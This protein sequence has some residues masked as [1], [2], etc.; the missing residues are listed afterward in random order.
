MFF[1]TGLLSPNVFY[2][3]CEVNGVIIKPIFFSH[4]CLCA[5]PLTIPLFTCPKKGKLGRSCIRPCWNTCSWPGWRGFFPPKFKVCSGV[6]SPG[7]TPGPWYGGW[8]EGFERTSFTQGGLIGRSHFMGNDNTAC[9]CVCVCI[10]FPLE[11]ATQRG[12]NSSSLSSTVACFSY[13][14]CFLPFFLASPSVLGASQICE[15]EPE[16]SVFLWCL[17]P[18]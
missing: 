3:A 18:A 16:H 17:F 6:R 1:L 2:L 14:V 5:C 7:L 12:P 9:V 4:S 10:Q 13:W 8:L 15:W 11:A